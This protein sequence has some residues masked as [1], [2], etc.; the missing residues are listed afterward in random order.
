MQAAR[1]RSK[2]RF[3]WG[4]IQQYGFDLVLGQIPRMIYGNDV[5]FANNFLAL[6]ELKNLQRR[7]GK[8]EVADPRI[9]F[10][11]AQGYLRFDPKYDGSLLEEVRRKYQSLIAHPGYSRDLGTRLATANRT[12]VDPVKRI[13]EIRFLLTL[14]IQD[15]LRGYYRSHFKIDF[16][17]AWRNFP[18]TETFS[19]K[20]V[21]SNLWHNDQEPVSALK[22]FVYLCDHVTRETGSLRLHPIPSTKEIM[23]M[24]Y[25][26]RRAIVGPAKHFIEDVSRIVFF[27]GDAG[28]ACFMN[29]Q[30]CLHRAGVPREGSYR[31][32]LQFSFSPSDRPISENWP[33]ELLPDPE[34]PPVSGAPN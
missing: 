25:L 14:E 26:K 17:R 27:E 22:L 21:Y 24:G 10:L 6:H 13:P 5:G 9:G 31:D 29:P 3:V 8:I 34:V 28:Q 4:A 2:A 18:L 12:V 16:V 20:D 23:R 7:S 1:P 33:S 32:V 19:N 15:I 11:R 30:L